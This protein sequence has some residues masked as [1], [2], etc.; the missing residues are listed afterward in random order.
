VADDQGRGGG[1]NAIP[2]VIVAAVARN[3]V[4]GAANRLVWKLSS[5]LRRFR[6]LTMGKPL[7]IG[8]KTYDSIGRPL[9]G[10]HTIVVTRN[11]G[12][13][14]EGVIAAPSLREALDRAREV[15]GRISAE[16]II[17]AGGGEI[18]RQAIDLA[19]RLYITEVD[20]APAGDV[21]FPAIDAA[22]WREVRR[23]KFDRGERDDADSVFVEYERLSDT[24]G[25]S[26]A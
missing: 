18:Y 25:A 26:A 9:P 14:V 20:L 4:I 11:A 5:D 22:R 1:L 10:R 12:F 15:A 21:H 2:I 6:S 3:G 16:E 13:K 17:V 7:V 19:Q 24:P 8:R 23:E